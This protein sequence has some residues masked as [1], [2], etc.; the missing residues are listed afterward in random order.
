[1][2][3]ARRANISAA[4]ATQVCPPSIP[5]SGALCVWERLHSDQ[6]SR[7]HRGRRWYSVGDWQRAV[8]CERLTAG[9]DQLQLSLEL[10]QSERGARAA[11]RCQRQHLQDRCG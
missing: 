3:R 4:A 9:R 7:R 8:R 11:G 5:E 1:M 10:T 6:L 2:I